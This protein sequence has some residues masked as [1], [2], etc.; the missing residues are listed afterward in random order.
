MVIPATGSPTVF[1]LIIGRRLEALRERAGLSL[2]EAATAIYT[3][4]WTIR[5]IERAE[6]GLKL[7]YV[8][9]LLQ[10]YGVTER[11][12]LDAFLDLARE[13]NKPGWWHDYDDVLPSWFRIFP[14]L[15]QAA[16]LIG[17]FEPQC[18]PG[19]LQTPGYARALA[20]AGT[21]G[22]SQADLERVVAVRMGRQQIL[23]DPSPP[24]LSLVIDESVLHRPVGGAAV[25]RA[26]LTHLMELATV[27]GIA[28]QVLPLRAGQHPAMC[29]MFHWLRFSAPELPDIVYGENLTGACY[30]DKPSEVAAYVQVLD[31]LRALAAPAERTTA[32]VSQIREKYSCSKEC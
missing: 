22:A 25:M 29:G 15:E 6:G 1:R 24:R 14:G 10:A 21:A 26:Q 28:L 11:G 32:I 18:V 3:S 13:A 8:A 20:A 30:L 5:R 12:Q 4:P 23:A 17:G 9:G 19:L 2:D 16:E 27:P 31:R 7:N